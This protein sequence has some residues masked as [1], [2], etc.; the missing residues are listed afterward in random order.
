MRASE[1]SSCRC[2]GRARLSAEAGAY[3]LCCARQGSGSA[4]PGPAKQHL[5]QVPALRA[6]VDDLIACRFSAAL[7]GLVALGP[8]LASDPFAAPQASTLAAR[9]RR[10]CAIQYLQPYCT[11]D[12]AAMAPVF[13]LT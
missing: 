6:L 5:D 2:V 12:L 8:A 1:R 11:V 10:H 3:S 4:S 13:G 9:V 7:R